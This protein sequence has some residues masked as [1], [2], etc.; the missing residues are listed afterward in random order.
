MKLLRYGPHKTEKPGN[1]DRSGS[2]RDLSELI[3]DASDDFLGPETISKL[4]MLDP[5]SLPLVKGSPR[6]GA[7]EGGVGKEI[8]IVLNF[9]DHAAESG[10]PVP[11]K[12][13]AFLKATSAIGG[14]YDNI[15]IPIGATKTDWEVELGV[16]IGEEAKNVS[17]NEALNHVAGYCV[18]NDLSARNFQL[19]RQ[20]QCA[21]GKS[22]DTFGP[23]GPWLATRDEVPDPQSLQMYLEVGGQRYQDEST[24]KMIYGVSFLVSYLSKF[25]SL[26]PGDIIS[27]GT[28]AGVGMGQ[29]PPVYLEPGD[30]LELE[31]EGL[32]SQCQSVAGPGGSRAQ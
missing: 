24:D 15:E 29:K 18:V 6:T 13:V 5:T 21:K 7:C 14:P 16:V 3:S 8:F 10:M 26:Q 2:I 25:T 4:S 28:P 22:A 11:P 12:S 19:E 30:L 9:S 31:I 32:G 1:L 17:E 27:T 20:G 23:I